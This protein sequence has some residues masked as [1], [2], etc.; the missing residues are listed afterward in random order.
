MSIKWRRRE[1]SAREEIKIKRQRLK[2]LDK[3]NRWIRKQRGGMEVTEQTL[4]K[5]KK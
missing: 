2:S 4:M 5:R 3:E 1:V